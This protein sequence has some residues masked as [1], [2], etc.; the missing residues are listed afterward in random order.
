MGQRVDIAGGEKGK[1]ADFRE[2]WKVY[3]IGLIRHGGG[4]GGAG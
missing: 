3:L 1:E 2:I 4:G